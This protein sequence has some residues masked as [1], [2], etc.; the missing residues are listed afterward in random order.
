M[1]AGIAAALFLA[2]GSAAAQTVDPATGLVLDQ[3]W[4][5]VRAHCTVCHSARQVTQQRGSRD[6]WLYVI[7]WMQKTQGLWQFD[8]VTEGAILDYLEKNYAPSASHRRA[9]LAAE[10]LP[11]VGAG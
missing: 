6:T 9:P 7:R 2:C 5:L 11:P 4:E 10:L 3:H 8:P 1:K